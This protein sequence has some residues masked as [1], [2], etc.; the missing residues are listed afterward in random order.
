MNISSPKT[1]LKWYAASKRSLPWRKTGDP[2][3]IW[4]SEVML[5]QTQVK[6]VVEFYEKFLE[7]FPRVQ[8]LARARW[9]SV[10]LVVRGMGYY[11]RFRNMQRTAQIIT[12]NFKGKFPKTYE[13][14]RTLPG[15]GDYTANAILA[16]AHNLHVPVIDTNVRRILTEWKNKAQHR[17]R[18]LQS[19]ALKICP[20]DRARDFFQAL[21]D[22]ASTWPDRRAK[23]KRKEKMLQKN[24]LRAAAGIIRQNGK[25]LIQK[26]KKGTHLAGFWEFPGGKIEPG[27]TPRACLK[28]EIKEEL[29][30]EVSVRPAFFQ[31]PHRYPE[32]SVFLSFHRC[33]ILLGRAKAREKQTFRWVLPQNLKKIKMAP[34]DVP[35]LKLLWPSLHKKRNTR[36][37]GK[38]GRS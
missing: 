22:Y 6:R 32:K 36:G 26:R 30:I 18:D 8:D 12:K 13:A 34:A 21:M 27:E 2:Y 17:S 28:R 11:G 7:K 15:I 29:G 1:L 20:P 33:Q 37:A 31:T 5:Q 3:Q 9:V 4:V 10:L 35:V 25:I 23:V 14:L 19:F 16:F 38:D 24:T